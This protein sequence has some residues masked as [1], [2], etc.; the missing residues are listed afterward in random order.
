LVTWVGEE[1]PTGIRITQGTGLGAAAVSARLPAVRPLAPGHRLGSYRLLVQLGQGAQGEVWK[2]LRLEPFKELV[3]LKVLKPAL[4]R[5]PARMAQFRRE[6]ERGVQLVGP[7]LLPVYELNT[8]DGHHFMAMPYIEGIT[9]RDVIKCRL[10]RLFDGASEEIHH[11]VNLDDREYLRAATRILAKV[12]RAMARVHDQQIAHR[13]IK[14]ANILLDS[15][16]SG[17]VYLCDFGLGRDLEVATSEQMRDGA[18]TL[19]YMAPERLLRA[20]ADEILCDVYSMGVTLFEATT[21]ERPYQLSAYVNVAS[22]PTL[23]ADAEPRR[24]GTVRPGF[25]EELEA[26]ILKAMARDPAH[27]HQS[28]HQLA[29]DLDRLSARRSLRLSRRPS[30]GAQQPSDRSP[31]DPS[32]RTQTAIRHARV[33]AGIGAQRLGPLHGP[34]SDS[35]AD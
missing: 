3:A 10:A 34:L 16:S 30:Q 21:L 20:P 29:S 14:P 8:I 19:M 17:G 18:G 33:S 28:A 5:S 13:D 32:G 23:L 22:I 24:P 25:P 11:L 27:R 12:A 26:I 4:S 15:H 31:H 1:I 35:P 7:S 2:A 6:A 9:L